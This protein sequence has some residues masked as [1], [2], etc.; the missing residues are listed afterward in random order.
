MA[1]GRTNPGNKRWLQANN[2]R[3]S[4]SRRTKQSNE[5][6]ISHPDA[7]V[8]SR[9]TGQI[10]TV[11]PVYRDR[12]SLNPVLQDRGE[13][14]D[15]KGGR[16]ERSLRIGGDQALIDVVTPRRRRCVGRTNSRGNSQDFPA[17]PIESHAAFREIDGYSRLHP[18][19]LDI[20]CADPSDQAVRPHRQLDAEPLASTPDAAE[21]PERGRY[22]VRVQSAEPSQQF[23]ARSR[24][25]AGFLRAHDSGEGEGPGAERPRRRTAAWLRASMHDLL[26]HRVPGGDSRRRNRRFRSREGWSR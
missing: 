13:S 10:G 20:P 18:H 16:A 12:A 4:H 7:A 11:C 21:H 17:A 8:R 19:E 1:L 2:D 22:A 24:V 6:R 23:A 26:G 9:T 25:G 3:G 15:T 5:H 14:R